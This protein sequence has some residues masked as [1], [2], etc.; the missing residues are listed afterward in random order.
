[1]GEKL[2]V[3][4]D[5]STSAMGALRIASELARQAGAGVEV[6]T[7]LNPVSAMNVLAIHGTLQPYPIGIETED[8]M[9]AVIAIQI[10]AAGAADLGWPI[11]L[12]SGSPG[13]TIAQAAEN[14][15]ASMILLGLRHHGRLEHLVRNETAISVAQHTQLPVL[16]VPTSVTHLPRCVLVAIDFEPPVLDALTDIVPLLGKAPTIH[17]VHVAWGWAVDNSETL[18]EFDKTYRVGA[19]SRLEYVARRMREDTKLPIEIHVVAGPAEGELLKLANRLCADLI[20]AG[21]HHHGFLQRSLIGNVS[22]G[23]LRHARCSVMLVGTDQEGRAHQR[24][25]DSIGVAA[26][27]VASLG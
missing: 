17:L 9:R 26:K 12:A 4:T 23:V 8:E 13:W 2:L 5:G 25:R 20:V 1:M 16:A 10:E 6:L 11:A 19:L 22:T 14:A 18:E 27:P 7:V 15:E 3:A 21:S 24:Q